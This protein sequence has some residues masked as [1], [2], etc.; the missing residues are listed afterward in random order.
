MA[1]IHYQLQLLLLLILII[2]L[3]GQLYDTA[4]YSLGSDLVQHGVFNDP[5]VSGSGW[6]Y[7]PT[8]IPGWDCLPMCE[9]KS[10]AYFCTPSHNCNSSWTQTIDLNS[11]GTYTI[12]RQTIPLS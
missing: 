11:A 10:L 4:S 6:Q 9:V 8:A 7:V 3:Q 12:L 5:D 2:T 1:T